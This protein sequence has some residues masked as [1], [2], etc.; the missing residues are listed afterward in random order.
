MAASPSLVGVAVLVIAAGLWDQVWVPL[1]A[2][3]SALK[4]EVRH[5]REVH[6]WVSDALPSLRSTQETAVAPRGQNVAQA[7]QA[8]VRRFGLSSAIARIEPRDNTVR[9]NIEDA[10]FD[11]TM[12]WLSVLETDLG[13]RIAAVRFAPG[14][15]DG[16]VSGSVLITVPSS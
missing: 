2:Q 11:A 1:D 14:S 9:I 10:R 15:D 13:L 4:A 8:S 6:A 3:R 5:A 7:I 12:T 16:F